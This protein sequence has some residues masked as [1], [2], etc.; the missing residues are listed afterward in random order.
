MMDQNIT[1]L[2]IAVLNAVTA[3]LSWRT[4]QLTKQV[5]LATNS[6]KDALVASTGKAAHAAGMEE[7]RL[8]GE[9]IASR[10]AKKKRKAAK[11]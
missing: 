8:A 9:L 2:I 11:S 4:H 10:L 7:G 5:E 6:M 3:Y 1:I